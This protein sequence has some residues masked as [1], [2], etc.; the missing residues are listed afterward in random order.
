MFETRYLPEAAN[1][2]FEPES[3]VTRSSGGGIE[4]F[5]VTTVEFDSISDSTPF[6]PLNHLQAGIGSVWRE[7]NNNNNKHDKLFFFFLCR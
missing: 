3:A 5:Y 2:S 6:T 7:L 4:Y 1:D